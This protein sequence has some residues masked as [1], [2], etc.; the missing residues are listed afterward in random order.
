MN[1]IIK[2]LRKLKECIDIIRP[3]NVSLIKFVWTVVRQPI[4]LLLYFEQTFIKPK[5][6]SKDPSQIGH[7]LECKIQCLQLNQKMFNFFKQFFYMPIPNHCLSLDS[8]FLVD[9]VEIWADDDSTGTG[10]T[11]HSHPSLAWIGPADSVCVKN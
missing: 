4:I 9:L 11:L 7:D 3:S 8:L 6:L 10:S 2:F 1:S 5:L